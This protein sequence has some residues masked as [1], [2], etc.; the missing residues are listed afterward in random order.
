MKHEKNCNCFDCQH[1][2]RND[3]YSG[4]KESSIGKYAGQTIRDNADEVPKTAD[5]FIDSSLVAVK[6]GE[7][8]NSP[9][10]TI[11][12]TFKKGDIVGTIYSWVVKDKK[13]WFELKA[14]GFVKGFDNLFDA[15]IAAATAS[16]LKHEKV[17]KE[18]K[19]LNEPSKLFT[20]IGNIFD[21]IGKNFGLLIIIVVL[22]AIA[23]S[24]DKLKF[25]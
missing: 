11:K 25:S 16:G 17:I 15:K 8:Y 1:G 2:K 5:Y 20:G 22:V 12:T 19:Q 4:I 23:Y 14:G 18:M 21:G 10:G 6:S 7:I 24:F 13:L 3:R 9:N